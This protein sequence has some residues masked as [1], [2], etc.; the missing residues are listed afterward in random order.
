[1]LD[2][3]HLKQHKID[4]FLQMWPTFQIIKSSP[5]N[6]VLLKPNAVEE[7]TILL[8]ARWLEESSFNALQKL[9]S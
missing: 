1:M 8:Y 9:I 3:L 2:T 5:K 4:F 7:S 6:L